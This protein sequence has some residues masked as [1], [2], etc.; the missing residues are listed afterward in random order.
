MQSFVKL[1]RN[2]NREF[3]YNARIKNIL[4]RLAEN[5]IFQL[6]FGNV[7]LVALFFVEFAVKAFVV[8]VNLSRMTCAVLGSHKRTAVAAKQFSAK[9]VFAVS[10]YGFLLMSLVIHYLVAKSKGLFVHNRRHYVGVGSAVTYN[11]AHILA[12][13]DYLGKRVDRE[14]R[15][16][17]VVYALRV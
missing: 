15:T 1:F 11:Y 8:V 13:A 14:L 7:R 10:L 2:S 12:V 17:F 6:L 9:Y 5:Q 16:G 4:D 3:V